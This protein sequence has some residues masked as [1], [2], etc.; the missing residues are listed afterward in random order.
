M[1][2]AEFAFR[3]LTTTSFEGHLHRTIIRKYLLSKRNYVVYNDPA[4]LDPEMDMRMAILPWPNL[5]ISNTIANM[6]A[7]AGITKIMPPGT[8]ASEPTR[9]EVSTESEGPTSWSTFVVWFTWFADTDEQNSE[10]CWS[11]FDKEMGRYWENHT[12]HTKQKREPSS[13]YT[14]EFPF[15]KLGEEE[16]I[17]IIS[18]SYN[19]ANIIW[20]AK[21]NARSKFL[22]G[23]RVALPTGFPD[24][25]TLDRYTDMFPNKNVLRKEKFNH[26][27]QEM[28]L[29]MDI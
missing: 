13:N 3:A 22:K 24:A 19:V 7:N 9:P 28:T 14:G 16:G 26:R 21:N 27:F 10:P 6:L 4:K 29:L 2:D 8:V 20:Q 12:W 15:A 5:W 1:G 17:L 23:V 18:W 25:E 11:R